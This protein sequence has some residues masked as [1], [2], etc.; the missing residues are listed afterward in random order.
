MVEKKSQE[1]LAENDETQSQPNIKLEVCLQLGWGLEGEGRCQG[2]GERN[3]NCN[4]L[5][6]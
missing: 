4:C 2:W 5:A 6:C 1:A 3:F